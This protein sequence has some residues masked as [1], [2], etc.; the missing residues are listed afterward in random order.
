MHHVSIDDILQKNEQAQTLS[1]I[2]E[3][4]HLGIDLVAAIIAWFSVEKARQA[5]QLPTLP[6]HVMATTTGA[7]RS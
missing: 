7:L 1:V 6:A 3:A 2:S 4:V 5:R